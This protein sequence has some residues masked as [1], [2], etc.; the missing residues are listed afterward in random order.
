MKRTICILLIA[1]TLFGCTANV[2]ESTPTTTVPVTESATEQTT[3]ETRPLDPIE[4]LLDSM[5][6]E[7]M[8]GQLFL[9]RYPG[10][11]AAAQAIQNSHIG[12]FLLFSNVF[13]KFQTF[14]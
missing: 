3:L 9:S 8:V 5:T 1:A 14:I 13:K 11:A 7:E 10:E 4:V 2:Q 12:S 6:T